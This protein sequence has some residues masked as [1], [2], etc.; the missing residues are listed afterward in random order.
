MDVERWCDE[1]PAEIGA[2]DGPSEYL[3]D[4]VVGALLSSGDPPGARPPRRG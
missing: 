2:A 1:S 4:R 3:L